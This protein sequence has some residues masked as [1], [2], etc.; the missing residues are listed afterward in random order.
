MGDPDG[1]VGDAAAGRVGERGLGGEG[2]RDVAGFLI[3]PPDEA[4]VL[5]AVVEFGKLRGVDEAG[6]GV[7]VPGLV[8]GVELADDGGQAIGQAAVGHG[9][10]SFLV[11]T[12]ETERGYGVGWKVAGSAMGRMRGEKWLFLRKSRFCDRVD[13]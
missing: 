1:E 3:E 8:G 9:G 7:E 13:A 11:V 5:G 6:A 4:V 2:E 10:G 12:K